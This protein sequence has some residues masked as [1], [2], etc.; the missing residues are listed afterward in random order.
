MEILTA[1]MVAMIGLLTK[2][3]RDTGRMRGAFESHVD[4]TGRVQADHDTRLKAQ[5]RILDQHALAIRR[6]A[7]HLKALRQG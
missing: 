3:S 1:L 2:I 6:Q 5:R 4:E 7:E